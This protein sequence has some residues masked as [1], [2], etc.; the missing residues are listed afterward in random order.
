MGNLISSFITKL[1]NI[2]NSISKQKYNSIDNNTINHCEQNTQNNIQHNIQKISSKDSEKDS[3]KESKPFI[4]SHLDCTK[5]QHDN[6]NEIININ[7]QNNG[8][9]DNKKQDNKNTLQNNIDTYVDKWFEK[10]KK[11]VNIGIIDIPLIGEVDIFPDSVE[12]S[13]HKKL[14]AT[15]ICNMLETEIC[16]AGVRMKLQPI[17]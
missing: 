17:H 10:N 16:I 1:K 15:M 11:D 3:E 2:Y 4:H 6:D 13:I 9:S 14:L 8:S 7:P 12:K 5:N